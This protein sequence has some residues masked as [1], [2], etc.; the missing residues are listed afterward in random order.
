MSGS[1]KSLAIEILHIQ[2]KYFQFLLDDC[3][4]NAEAI[5]RWGF[6]P[7]EEARR[8]KHEQVQSKVY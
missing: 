6:T 4:M 8:F 3:G 5:D 2:K 1:P 7:I